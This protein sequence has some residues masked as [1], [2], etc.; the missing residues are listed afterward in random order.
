MQKDISLIRFILEN[1]SNAREVLPLALSPEF[2]AVFGKFARYK[3][4][5]VVHFQR[6]FSFLTKANFAQFCALSL[7]NE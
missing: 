4:S 2:T 1:Y 7:A 3:Q 6:I 5:Y